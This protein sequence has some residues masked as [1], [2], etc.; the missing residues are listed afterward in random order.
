MNKKFRYVSMLALTSVW[1]LFAGS[2]TK[3]ESFNSTENLTEQTDIDGFVTADEALRIAQQFIENGN[4]DEG[5]QIRSTK[6]PELKVVYTDATSTRST[7]GDKPSY[8]VINLDTTGYVI[9]SASEVTYPVLGYSNESAFSEKAIPSSMRSILSDFAAEIKT[10]KESIKPSSTTEQMRANALR[11]EMTELRV[12]A[13]VQPILG[14]IKWDQMPYYNQFCPPGTPVGCVATATCQIMRYWEHPERGTGK[15]VSTH[16]GQEA[17]Y[18]HDL[19]WNNMPQATLTTWNRDVAQ[20]CYDVAIGLNMQFDTPKNG[21]SGTFQTYVPGMLTQH[22]YYKDTA[23][24]VY[25]NRYT[26][27]QWAELIREELS[28]G[29]P[30]QYA[31]YGDGGGHSFVCDGYNTRGYFHFNWG[32]GGASDG[33]FL[34]NALNP[35]SLGTGGGNGGFNSGQQAV[36][37]IE[38][39]LN[40]DGNDPVNPDPIEPDPI[41]PNPVVEYCTSRASN[42]NNTY[43]AGVK[44]SDLNNTSGAS[45]TGYQLF[46]NTGSVYA[47]RTYTM[48]LTPGFSNGS[49]M[50]YWGAWID[51][52]NNQVFESNERV[53]SSYTYGS[54]FLNRTIYIPS[55]AKKGQVRMRV[56]TKWGGYP[57]PCE[58]F[59]YGEVEDYNITIH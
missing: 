34:L 7:S 41:E 6:A 13:S 52:N 22:Y 37:G 39:D 27:A 15:H 56:T 54:N 53:I 10:A 1:A 42:S 29:R 28:N 44:L 4:M 36:I 51:F 23:R 58:N 16:D 49:Y 8:Y 5:S 24:V 19:N 46:S 32:W 12:A 35:G 25:R 38:P 33:Y 26:M 48:T 17:N 30:V 57:E 43:I 21:G 55:G 59:Y 9:V 14:N 3:E 2:C 47:G 11:G 18:D 20:F 31:G 40:N 45:S 50:M